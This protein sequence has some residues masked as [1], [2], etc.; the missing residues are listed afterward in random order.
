[1]NTGKQNGDYTS[2]YRGV[3]FCEQTGMWA[4]TI[5]K[6]NTKIWIGRYHT[7]IEGAKAYDKAAKK[8]HGEFA[9]LNF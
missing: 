8:I 1:M 9:N 6:N 4:V 2:K 7:E 5:H 3:C